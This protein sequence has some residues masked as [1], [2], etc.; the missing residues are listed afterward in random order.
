M[1][2]VRTQAKAAVGLD[3]LWKAL[4]KELR[5]VVPKA[6]PNLV[7]DV[8][9]IEGDG[10]LGSVLL[11]NFCSDASPMTYQREKIVELE[12]SLH[13]IALEVIEGGHLNHG[14]SSYK[15]TFMLTAIGEQETLVDIKVSYQF[16]QKDDRITKMPLKTTD[17]T[18]YFI[19]CLET[20]L[21]NADS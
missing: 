13:Q 5:F 16:D 4:T 10:G 1:E 19:K 11:F 12:E 20:Y 2:E 7:K 6:I 3:I 15:T 9:M 8:E 17:S 14:F 18:L 21:L